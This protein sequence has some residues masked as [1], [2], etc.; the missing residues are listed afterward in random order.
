MITVL[1]GGPAGATASLLLAQWGHAVRLIT[2]AGG[3]HHLAVSLP[4]SCDKL[5]RAIGVADA[6]DRAG[7]IRSTGN[8]VWWGGSA[9]RVE[10][11]AHGARGW[12]VD[13]AHLSEVML[14]QAMASGVQVERRMVVEAPPYGMVL[15]CTGRSGVIARARNVRR[16]A[17]AAHTIALI[18][19]WRRDG[20]W[21]VPD[22]THTLIESYD[23]GWVWSVPIGAGVRHIAAMI[24][25]Q[26]SSLARGAQSKDVYLTELGKT[27]VFKDLIANASL[28]GGPWGW[29]A[30]QYDATEY[31]GDD[32]LLVGDAGSFIDP[33]S[34]AGVKK[35]LASAWLAAVTIHTSVVA[36]AM[37]AHAWAFFSA[38]EREITA[39]L[40]RESSRFLAAAASGHPHAFWDERSESPTEEIG[41]RESIERAFARLKSRDALTLRLGDG[42]GVEPRPMIRGHEIV[43]EPHLIG[44]AHAGG[45][46]FVHKVDV[47]AMARLGAR[48]RSVPDLFEAYEKEVGPAPL[49]DFLLAL[50]TALSRGWLVA[51]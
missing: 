7:F 9:A 18:G 43:L 29:N 23:D 49:H 25:P 35:A 4:P 15:D 13:L 12:Q 10:S 45:V 11:F 31:A 36:P 14:T 5:F 34:S 51:Y 50:A 17:S 27:R 46:R 8:T 26:R 16:P 41:D 33:L 22:G 2:K 32:W 3:D 44:P 37:R 6:I 30:S 21:P 38:R 39:H 1:G 28:N 19:E 20:A 42:V 47:V 48:I 40:V 24:D